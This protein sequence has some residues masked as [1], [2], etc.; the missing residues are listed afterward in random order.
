MKVQKL[1]S[2]LALLAL[3]FWAGV[4]PSQAQDPPTCDQLSEQ[5]RTIGIGNPS[6]VHLEAS[7]KIHESN[8]VAQTFKVPGAGCFAVNSI[9]LR[10]VRHDRNGTKPNDLL[11]SIFGTTYSGE[12]KI[13]TGSALGSAT[14]SVDD[15][16]NTTA[17][18]PN[19]VSPTAFAAVTATFDPP[20]QVAGGAYYAVVI[21]QEDGGGDGSIWYSVGLVVGTTYT[22]AGL[23]RNLH[24]C[25]SAA[26]WECPATG[27]LTNHEGRDITMTIELV[28]CAEGCTLT[29]GFWKNHGGDHPPAPATPHPSAWPPTAVPMLLGLNPVTHSYPQSELLRI[30]RGPVQGNGAISLSKQLIAAKLNKANGA[31][32][33]AAIQQTMNDADGLIATEPSRIPPIGTAFLATSATG[34]YTLALDQYNNGEWPGGPLHCDAQ[35]PP[36]FEE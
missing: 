9:T 25:K 31:P 11:L 10:A 14:I 22:E 7:G 1:S 19:Q 26:P 28:C 35:E 2:M 5:D 34:A 32:V 21:E 16:P 3:V 18:A 13:P 8:K 12:G 4:T 20:I 24:Y 30:L 17:N 33:P 36:P 6:Q 15:I 29:Q 27:G 23:P